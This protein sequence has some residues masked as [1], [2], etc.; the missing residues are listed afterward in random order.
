MYR[1]RG[2]PAVKGAEPPRP[3]VMA[4][5][6]VLGLI[7]RKIGETAQITLGLQDALSPQDTL[8]YRPAAEIRALQNLDRIH[9]TLDDCAALLRVIAEQ[10]PP[11]MEAPLEPLRQGVILQETRDSLRPATTQGDMPSPEDREN[12]IYWL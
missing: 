8:S 9:Q 5:C 6:D 1:S 7:A 12:G 11:V 3:D 4:L 2:G 10:L